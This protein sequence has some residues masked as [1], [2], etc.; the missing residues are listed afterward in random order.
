MYNKP[1]V[2]RQKRE[3]MKD[4]RIVA[5]HLPATKTPLQ[6]QTRSVVVWTTHLSLIMIFRYLT[7]TWRTRRTRRGRI[8][9][10]R[11]GGKRD[12]GPC[13]RRRYRLAISGLFF[14]FHLH[15]PRGTEPHVAHSVV[16]RDVHSQAKRYCRPFPFPVTVMQ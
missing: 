1:Q 6:A 15:A 3:V 11:T 8:T 12:V 9:I 16:L 14:R 2:G 4:G 7:G 5:S 13:I 10:R